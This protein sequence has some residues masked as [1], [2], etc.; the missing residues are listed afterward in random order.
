MSDL[1]WNLEYFTDTGGPDAPVALPAT[2]PGA[3]TFTANWASSTRA[4]DYLL[5]VST[6][7]DFGS[8]VEGYHDRIVS[9]LDEV[10]VGVTGLNYYRLRARNEFGTSGYSNVVT[11]LADFI[12]APVATAATDIE[13]NGFTAN[14]EAVDDDELDHYEVE[15]SESADFDELV[16]FGAALNAGTDLSLAIVGLAPDTEHFYRVRALKANGTVSDPSNVIS[17]TTDPSFVAQG[18]DVVTYF[19]DVNETVHIFDNSGDFEVLQGSEPVRRLLVGGGGSG[20]SINGSGVSTGGGGAGGVLD[21]DEVDRPADL[22]V[23]VYPVVV[24]AGGVSPDTTHSADGGNSTFNGDTAIGGGG[25]GGATRNGRAGGSGG[26]AGNGNGAGELG[27]AGTAGQGTAGGNATSVANGGGGGGGGASQAGGAGTLAT[28]GKGGDGVVSDITGANVTYAGGGGGAVP[29]DPFG[30]LGGTT[31]GAGGAGGGAAGNTNAVAGQNATGYGSGGGGT[32][33]ANKGGNGSK[34]RVV[35]R[36]K[37]HGLDADDDSDVPAPVYVGPISFADCLRLQEVGA[38]DILVDCNARIDS[39]IYPDYQRYLCP[40]GGVVQSSRS[41][42]PNDIPSQLP[43][44]PLPGGENDVRNGT[45]VF[46]FSV[47]IKAFK[48]T[49]KVTAGTDAIPILVACDD[50][51]VVPHP[52]SAISGSS[53]DGSIVGVVKQYPQAIYYPAFAYDPPQNLAAEE[54]M[55]ITHDA[56]F[57]CVVIVQST[58]FPSEFKDPYFSV[59]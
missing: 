27:G 17:A 2:D 53:K 16:P 13:D 11:A 48:I 23:G 10:V 43:D 6:D 32:R 14:W 19:P 4:R 58:K 51:T 38:V 34:G 7:P 1:P 47:P 15:V 12:E 40:G 28:G 33:G 54:V 20:G 36:Y 18:G 29:V 21:L 46:R 37:G 56:G 45:L 24:G 57:S 52:T 50:Y 26:G 55:E 5:D 44:D 49:R 31:P 42:R 8:Y 3:G 25:G 59:L 41:M 35:I 9:G 39:G 30:P 22:D